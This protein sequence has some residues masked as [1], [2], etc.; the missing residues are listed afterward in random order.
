MIFRQLIDYTSNTYTYM[1]ASG[2]GREAVIIDP[3]HSQLDKYITLLN[4][5]D[6]RLA[7][8]IDTHT[9]ADHITATGPL[10][11]KLNCSVA[12]GV[13]SKA[14]CIT[15]KLVEGEILHVDGIHLH[16][17]YTPGHT[18]DSY[19]FRMNDRIFTGDTLMIHATGRTDF[20]SGDA[21]QQYDSLF[22]KLLTLPEDMHVFP[23]HDYNGFT[24]TTIGEEKRF[25]PRLQVNSADEYADIMNQLHLPKP[26]MI[27]VAVPH[28]LKCGL[29][30]TAPSI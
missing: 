6:I 24:S 26:K 15:T 7:F 5:L 17:M 28:N 16:A 19:S 30:Y 18:D 14:E 20:Q 13:H 2:H 10:R 12:M 22:N 25:N 3:V 9:H 4:E 27:D 21:H 29:E 1:L 8:A 11:Q 23:A